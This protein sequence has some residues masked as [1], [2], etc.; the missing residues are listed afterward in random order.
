MIS[1]GGAF[2]RTANM[3]N[4][5]AGSLFLLTAAK[6]SVDYYRHRT[7][8]ITIL[9]FVATLSAL[10]GL[11]FHYSHAWTSNWW[12]WHVLRLCAHISLVIYLLVEFLRLMKERSAAILLFEQKNDELAASEQT[13][14]ALNQQLISNQQRLVEE[15]KRFETLFDS[16]PDAIFIAEPETG[17][18]I[19]AN[20]AAVELTRYPAEKL[21]GM[22]QSLL[23]PEKM[24]EKYGEK[25]RE[26]AFNDSREPQEVVIQDAQGNIVPV[27]VVGNVVKVAGKKIVIGI[28]RDI[29][30]RKELEK[31]K[32]AAYR[33]ILTQKQLTDSIL[34]SLPGIF[35]QI[36]MDGQ[37]KRWNK[38]FLAVTGLTDE[39]MQA[40][41]AVDFFREDDI[42]HVTKA[43]ETVFTQGEAE[44]EA[45]LHIKSGESIPYLFT[46]VKFEI[47][48]NPYILGMGLDISNLRSTQNTLTRTVQELETFNKMA[49]GRELR[50]IELKAQINS[51]SKELGKKAPYDL[52]FAEQ[53]S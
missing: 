44:V 8:G 22:H 24:R 40:T 1:E 28:F 29:T 7:I 42:N 27:E 3:I 15:K 32:E 46:G 26:I 47:E 19:N 4:I 37:Y 38:K 51:L 11:T 20:R 21:V 12:F 43:M 39:E 53:D 14:M 13:L 10:A 23:H 6:L 50:M 5:A 33:N 25:F 18:L 34:D 9:V 52:Q 31:Q 49:V 36:G 45:D 48:G 16:E 35:Y 41:N 17:I 30:A 2:T